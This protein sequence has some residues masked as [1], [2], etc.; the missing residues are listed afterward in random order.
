M[1]ELDIEFI[2]SAEVFAAVGARMRDS[3]IRPKNMVDEAARI[4]EAANLI[5][6][7][8]LDEAAA[9]AVAA[10]QVQGPVT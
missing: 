2:E 7:A 10:A 8:S 9:R 1:P 3:P 4:L 5:T 6:A